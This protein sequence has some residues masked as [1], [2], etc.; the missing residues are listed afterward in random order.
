M[1]NTINFRIENSGLSGFDGEMY[2]GTEPLARDVDDRDLTG[3]MR[4]FNLMTAIAPGEWPH[5]DTAI[6]QLRGR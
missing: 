3:T 5:R 4:E 2:L 6:R 1:N